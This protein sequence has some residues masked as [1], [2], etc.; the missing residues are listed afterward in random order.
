MSS[1]HG[2]WWA[3]WLACTG[4]PGPARWLTLRNA[5]ISRG[6]GWNATWPGA[7]R[8]W[9]RWPWPRET[10]HR[11]DPP[12]RRRRGNAR[13]GLP[14]RPCR[15]SSQP[16]RPE[17]RP[18]GDLTGAERHS[19]RS[20]HHRRAPRPDSRPRHRTGSPG[21]CARL[22]RPHQPA[23]SISRLFQGRDDAD[24]ARRLAVRH[25]L[26]WHELDA[27]TAHSYSGRSRRHQSRLGRSRPR[28]LH[29]HLA[30]PRLAPIPATA[31]QR[32]GR[33]RRQHK[34]YDPGNRGH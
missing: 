14:H 12:G 11:H 18:A 26:P 4:R 7:T 2:I 9:V 27:L 24:A 34:R 10:C 16:G 13:R 28:Q 30:P 31:R 20:D 32:R 33:Q 1:G 8:C 29:A 22:R 19:G 17:S 25:H 23:K 3:E 21:Q 15:G 6:N 5:D